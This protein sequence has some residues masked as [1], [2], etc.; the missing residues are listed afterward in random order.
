MGLFV[1]KY[2]M[3]RQERA[4]SLDKAILNSWTT[5]QNVIAKKTEN[6]GIVQNGK[7]FAMP[8]YSNKTLDNNKFGKYMWL[9]K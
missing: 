5:G 4:K 2:S 3:Q 8:I 7:K 6:A 1:M 9:I